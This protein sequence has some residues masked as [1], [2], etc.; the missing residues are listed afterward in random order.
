MKV[1][2][3]L[4]FLAG[5]IMGYNDLDRVRSEV[6]RGNYSVAE[7]MIKNI[8]EENKN[9]PLLRLELKYELERMDRIKKDFTKTK[10][11]VL[12]YVKRYYPDADESSLII[13]EK[14]GALEYKII[15]GE[16]LYFNRAAANIFRID[17]NAKKKKNEVT[18]GKKDK[19]DEFLEGYLPEVVKEAVDSQSPFAK[20]VKLK[21]NYTL[22]VDPD[23]VPGGEM[24]RAWLPYPREAH[25]RQ[26]GVK[27][28]S[29][30]EKNY[31]IAPPETMQRSIYMEKQAEAGKPV[32]FNY[33]LEYFS[34][35]E[36]Y[37]IDQDKVQPFDKSS[38]EY[39]KYTSERAPHIVFTDRIKK[40]SEKIVG[41]EKNPY[42][43]AKKIFTWISENIPWAGAREY[44]TIRNI[45]DYCADRGH[46]DCGIK[47]LLFVT[48][49]RYNGIP[50]KWQSGWMF[51]PGIVNLH[52]WGAFYLEGYGWLPVDQSFGI[53]ESDDEKVK[54]Y[55]LGGMDAYRYIVN[56]DYSAPLFP[57]KV[58]PRSETVDFQRGEVEWRGGNLYYDQWDYEMKVE[59]GE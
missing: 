6:D 44:S 7:R 59:Y 4:I 5:S 28:I 10:E 22:T 14:N 34:E 39:K 30:S 47:T 54:Y 37:D 20:K 19:L 53:T 1:I 31:I 50:A 49:C 52:D 48:L 51:H 23:V 17:K 57:A 27:F 8:L 26:S 21:I 56:D 38:E 40:L 55:F 32:V 46:G 13:W 35:N 11:S 2:L 25:K 3:L 45:S 9:D 18:G 29:A 42:L 41:N 33:A 15:D 24:V 12:E 16:K 43:R 58:F 36:W